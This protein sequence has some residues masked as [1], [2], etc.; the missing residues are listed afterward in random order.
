MDRAEHQSLST[1]AGAVASSGTA[2]LACAACCV[3]P[4]AWPAAG[5]V[6]TGGVI[7]WLERAQPYITA[8]AALP[9]ALG[10]WLALR[11]TRSGK[12]RHPWTLPLLVGATALIA[13]AIFWL[14]IEPHLIRALDSSA[15]AELS[16]GARP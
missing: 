11:P 9:V 7:V 5:L 13:I 8:I 3:L 6:L 10:W 15:R 4:L 14:R 16:Q 1:P 2:V 12:R